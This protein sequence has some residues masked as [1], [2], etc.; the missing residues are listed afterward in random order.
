MN[1]QIKS[2]VLGFVLASLLLLGVLTGLLFVDGDIRPVSR[3]QVLASGK[4]V[5]ITSLN[6]VWGV[7][8]EERRTDDDS[9]ALECVSSAANG[10]ETTLD[11]E[12]LEVFELIRPVSE[13]WGFS[14]ASISVF[15]T[16][17]RKG[18]YY[19][20]AFTRAHDG[21]WTFGR[22]SAKVHIND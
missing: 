18:K 17:Q 11:R 19:I 5:K 2:V 20:Y 13:Q 21:Q 16:T 14:R 1:V 12:T 7:E 6:L 10:D 4:T 15:S 22:H 3:D 9:F 8:H